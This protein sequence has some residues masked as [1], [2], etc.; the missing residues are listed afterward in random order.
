LFSIQDR[1]EDAIPLL[2]FVLDC[3]RREKGNTDPVTLN[4]IN[5]LAIDLREIGE[6]DEAETLFRELV[7]A[8]QQVLEPEDF[9]IGRALGG[10]AKTLE[11]AGKLE[12]ALTY[13]QQALDH[14]LAQEGPDAWWTN[15]ERFDLARV[16]LKLGHKSEAS[17]LLQK[18]MASMNHNDDLDDADRQLISDAAEL[19]RAT[20]GG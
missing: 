11:A 10:L 19:L 3:H 13:S 20:Y 6:L 8:R 15:R 17:A 1:Q 18:L 4:S 2:H 9:Q 14:R 7:A 5:D 12:E 16:L